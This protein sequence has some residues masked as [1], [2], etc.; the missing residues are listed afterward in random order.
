MCRERLKR[1][2]AESM[3]EIGVGVHPVVAP[4]G[5]RAKRVTVVWA[6]RGSDIRGAYEILNR[7]NLEI[8][9]IA[10]DIC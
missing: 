3:A 6:D 5:G 9:S 10:I 4:S 8:N 2:R 7:V 1:W